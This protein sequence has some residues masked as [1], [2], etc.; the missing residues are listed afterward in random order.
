MKSSKKRKCLH[1]REFYRPDRRNLRHQR[2]CSS[3]DCQKESKRQSQCRWLTKSGNEDYFHG[4]HHS[5]RVRRWREGNPGYARKKSSSPQ[6]PLQEVSITQAAQHQEVT[7][8]KTSYALQDF[9]PMQPALFVGL[10]ATMTG[11]ALQED[12][13]ATAR[14]L[15]RKGQ[16]ILGATQAGGSRFAHDDQ[17]RSLPRE[18]AACSAPV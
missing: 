11:S 10:I 4:A 6:E 16:D 8:A 14:V 12:I 9:F 18:A 13:E 2:Y 7:D 3:P 5:Q 15:L 17:T 1:C